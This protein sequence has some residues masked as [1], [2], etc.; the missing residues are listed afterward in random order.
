MSL[1][2]E[3]VPLPDTQPI[4]FDTIRMRHRDCSPGTIVISRN[5]LTNERQ[6]RCACGLEVHFSDGS[7][8]MMEITRTAIDEVPRSLPEGAFTCTEQGAVLVVPGGGG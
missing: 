3:I 4:A 2:I 6:L 1:T 8:A 7:D 5:P